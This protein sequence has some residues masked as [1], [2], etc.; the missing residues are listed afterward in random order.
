MRPAARQ[1]NAGLIS[2]R[3]AAHGPGVAASYL[4]CSLCP[5]DF[6]VEPISAFSRTNAR[7]WGAY[8]PL[9]TEVEALSLHLLSEA[10]VLDGKVVAT[11]LVDNLAPHHVEEA[12]GEL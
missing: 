9:V 11:F 6:P 10:G 7:F 1:A 8:D 12:E 4:L 5:L 3:Q 2:R